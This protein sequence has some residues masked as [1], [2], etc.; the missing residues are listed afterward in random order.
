MTDLQAHVG[1]NELRYD[2]ADSGRFARLVALLDHPSP[3]RMQNVIPPLGHW[4]CFLPDE[5]QS[6]IGADGH[7]VRSQEGL[8]PAT[9]F[10]RRMWAGSRIEFRA[11]IPLNVPIVRTSTLI[12]IRSKQGRSGEMLFATLR[13]EI[14]ADRDEAAIVEEQDIVFREAPA[15]SAPLPRNPRPVGGN[16]AATAQVRPDTV[17]LF[18]YSALTYNAHRIHYDGDYARDV[19]GYPGL[20]VQGPFLATL[21]IDRLRIEAPDRTIKSFVFRAESPS[22]AGELLTLGTTVEGDRATLRAVGPFGLCMTAQA[23]FRA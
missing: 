18:R 16:D 14:G 17:M 2:F 3:H 20:V 1:R 23:E 11:D 6:Q 7:P 19:E 13:H 22:F 5:R 12:S 9:G 4:L 15:R 8:L 21:L 10:P